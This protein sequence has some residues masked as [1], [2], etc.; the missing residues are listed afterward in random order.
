MLLKFPVLQHLIFLERLGCES[1][2]RK[3]W[4]LASISGK[5]TVVLHKT[6]KNETLQISRDFL[7]T[8]KLYLQLQSTLLHLLRAQQAILSEASGFSTVLP[9]CCR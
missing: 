6:L 8:E 5:Q 9:K 2:S 3:T 4:I 1:A 7:R